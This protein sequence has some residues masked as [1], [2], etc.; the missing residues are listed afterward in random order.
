MPNLTAKQATAVA[1]NYFKDIY[2]PTSS[3][4]VEEIEFDHDR[5]GH[6]LITLGFI[7]VSTLNPFEKSAKEF[8]VFDVEDQSGQVLSMKIRSQ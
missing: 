2:G 7:T 1:V 8:K 4:T 6:W 5:G 3:V